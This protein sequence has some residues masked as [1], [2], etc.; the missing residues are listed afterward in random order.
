MALYSW[1][2]LVLILTLVAA[3]AEN[4][5]LTGFSQGG[6]LALYTGLTS[7]VTLGERQK[8]LDTFTE[9]GAG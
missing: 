7:P 3:K 2:R 4:I 8:H 9:N 6:A 1:S 5:V